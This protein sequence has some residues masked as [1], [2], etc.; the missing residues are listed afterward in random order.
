MLKKAHIFFAA[1][2]CFAF[3]AL[4]PLASAQE[5]EDIQSVNVEG[6]KRIDESTI[7]Y[8]I[9]SKPGTVLSKKQIREDIEQIYSL[10]QFKD[11]RVET[12]E[13]LK[14]ME[15]EFIVEEIT[16]IG[17][18]EIVG[19]DKIDAND[20][21]EKI[22]L[23]RG[24]TFNEHLVLESNEEILKLYREKGYFFAQVNIDTESG[25]DNLVSVSIRVKEGEKVKIEKI[26]FSGNK[27]FPDKDLRGQ[28]E[29]QEKTWYSFLDD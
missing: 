29:T 22:G 4:V 26:R 2:I 6:N 5:G 1:L 13:T 15:I 3:L 8:Y 11:I 12:R 28:M 16:S 14:G 7:L 10:G 21:R 25:Q 17:D 24:A 19:S 23:K 20:I 18:V 27:A 9:K